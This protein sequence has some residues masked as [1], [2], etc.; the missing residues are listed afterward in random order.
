MK[1]ALFLAFL[2]VTVSAPANELLLKLKSNLALATAV[3]S[4]TCVDT[5]VGATPDTL[6]PALSFEFENFSLQWT[7]KDTSFEFVDFQILLE[8]PEL[9]GGKYTCHING[10]ELMAVLNGKS[11]IAAGDS[12]VYQAGCG[13]RCG[14]LKF[15]SA[16]ESPSV[17]KG[18]LTVQGFQTDDV[19]LFLP[20]SIEIPVS[21]QIENGLAARL[22]QFHHNLVR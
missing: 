20:S 4:P 1:K 5:Q 3:E 11:K 22:P 16:A 13:L 15:K 7:G 12:K 9:V 19:D 18:S 21:V 17:V 14:G 2:F 6:L 8:S 10:N